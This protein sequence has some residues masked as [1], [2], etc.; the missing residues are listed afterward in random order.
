MNLLF[1]FLHEYF[2]FCEIET[3]LVRNV[4]ILQ[5]FDKFFN[6]TM[7]IKILFFSSA[8]EMLMFKGFIF[9]GDYLELRA[10]I[11]FEAKYFANFLVI[12]GSI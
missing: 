3:A 11:V 2:L 7:Q 9:G 1:E 12:F 8:C 4:T 10:K 5:Q 6:S